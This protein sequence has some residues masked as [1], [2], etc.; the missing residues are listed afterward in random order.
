MKV[1]VSV[2]EGKEMSPKR[3]NV[4]HKHVCTL[5][6]VYT[7]TFLMYNLCETIHHVKLWRER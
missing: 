1:H 2:H 5:A 4:P 6:A 7:T 3:V